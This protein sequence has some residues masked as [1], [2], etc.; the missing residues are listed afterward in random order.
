MIDKNKFKNKEFVENYN[1]TTLNKP[2]IK[3]E[4]WSFLLIFNLIILSWIL[5]LLFLDYNSISFIKSWLFFIVIILFIIF[6]KLYNN[7]KLTFNWPK[8]VWDIIWDYLFFFFKN[9][10]KKISLNKKSVNILKE[11]KL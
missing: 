11:I 5:L 8:R 6:F 4:V 2:K 1:I 7:Y 9:F 3:L 10:N